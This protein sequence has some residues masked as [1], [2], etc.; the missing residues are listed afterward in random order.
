MIC[1]VIL[2]DVYISP[3]VFYCFKIISTYIEAVQ[4]IDPKLA[5]GK[6]STLWVAFAK[7]YENGKQLNDVSSAR[8]SYSHSAICRKIISYYFKGIRTVNNKILYF[9][10]LCLSD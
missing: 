2:P 6:L 4:S 10:Q 7:F 1:F 9:V 5:I 8:I 3:K